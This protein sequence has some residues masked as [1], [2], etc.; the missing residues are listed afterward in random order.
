MSASVRAAEAY[1]RSIRTG[2]HGPSVALSAL[3]AA[4]VVLDTNGLMAGSP[5]ETISGHDKVLAR[6][7][8]RWAVTEALSKAR[9]GEPRVE[10]ATVK[11]D[12]TFEYV[13][14]VSPAALSLAF[15]FSGDGKISRI[16]QRYTPKAAPANTDRI[17]PAVKALINNA[18]T[19]NTPFVIA[20]VD[21]NNVPMIT[22]RGS[23]QVLNDQQ[24]CVWIR[25]AKGGLVSAVAKN[26]AVSLAYRDGS[27]SM[28]LIQ[29][30]AHV[31]NSEDMRDRVFE[32]TPEVE[33][34]HD[35]A[36]KGCPMIIDVDRMMG[37]TTGG[38]PVRMARKA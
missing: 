31:D 14:G 27:N 7:S 17:S 8:G 9:W 19:N 26:P 37:F 15:S 10:G 6:A 20:H 16:E 34:N 21:E 38:E 3:L 4:D 2:E 36:R 13:G 25:Q 35:P 30:R 29:G 11:V 1:I 18:R 32:L 22:F 12:A 5:I 33:Q 28:L 23:I 24:L